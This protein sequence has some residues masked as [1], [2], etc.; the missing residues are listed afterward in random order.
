MIS[1]LLGD[2]IQKLSDARVHARHYLESLGIVY[3]RKWL[4]IYN[5]YTKFMVTR[6]PL[7]R[8]MSGY[9]NMIKPPPRDIGPSFS[10]NQWIHKQ[11]YGTPGNT[12]ASF[13]DFLKMVSSKDEKVQR[14]EFYNNRHWLPITQVCQPCSVNYDYIV[15]LETANHDSVPILELFHINDTLPHKNDGKR[16]MSQEQLGIGQSFLSEY[17]NIPH[18]IMKNVFDRYALD[19]ALYGYK[20]EDV[21]NELSCSIR[22][23]DGETC[24]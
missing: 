22:L 18:D 17:A 19:F 24:C 7:D 16:T 8:L 6:H 21:K 4:P 23:D 5:N 15:R 9:K 2:K 13:E 11:L 12:I 20:Y 3:A 1:S 10:Y 14:S